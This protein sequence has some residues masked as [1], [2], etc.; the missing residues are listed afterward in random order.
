MSDTEIS[1]LLRT[2]FYY[3][4]NIGGHIIQVH[5][6]QKLRHYLRSVHTPLPPPPLVLE[7]ALQG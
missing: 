4:A 2:T 3:H 1:Q 7:A 6:Q 5:E